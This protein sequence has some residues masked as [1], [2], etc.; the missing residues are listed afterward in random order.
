MEIRNLALP[1][2]LVGV[3]AFILYRKYS[4]LSNARFTFEGIAVNSVSPLSITAYLGVQNVTS[5]TATVGQIQG[6]ITANG[7]K[8]ATV[9]VPYTHT[10][11]GNQK[12]TIP[13]GVLPTIDIVTAINVIASYVNTSSVR[14]GFVGSA[15]VD[16]INI[17]VNT[18]V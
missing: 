17:N 18:T 16:G 6:Y 11:L 2:A 13:V 8:I 10:I 7:G 5:V 15:V 14:M 1:L 4:L 12:T 9:S 3:G